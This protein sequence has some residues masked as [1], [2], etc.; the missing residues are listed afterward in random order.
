MFFKGCLALEDDVVVGGEVFALE[1]EM[2]EEEVE[3]EEEV[4]EFDEDIENEPELE[5]QGG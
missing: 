2:E 5:G 1:V 3:V 4:D